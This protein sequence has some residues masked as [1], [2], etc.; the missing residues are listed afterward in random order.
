MITTQT[1]LAELAVKIPAASRVFQRYGLD[2]CCHGN[3]GFEEACAEQGLSPDSKRKSKSKAAIAVSCRDG[4][5]RLY[6]NSLPTS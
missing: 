1:T 2:F 5:K 3:R 4:S 6:P